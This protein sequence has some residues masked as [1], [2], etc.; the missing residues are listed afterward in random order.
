MSRSQFKPEK[1]GANEGL[2][3]M[4]SEFVAANSFNA[5]CGTQT[6]SDPSQECAARAAALYLKSLVLTV[7][8]GD[9]IYSVAAF[10]M[11]PQEA[12]MWKATLPA[13]RSDFWSVIKN[14]KQ[15]DEVLRFFAAGIVAENPQKFGLK[16][17]QPISKLYP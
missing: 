4:N 13:D 1:Q 12:N 10:G 8:E 17:D 11:S 2:W 3:Q 7:F 5:L 9:E 14:P 6:L 16:N 15:R